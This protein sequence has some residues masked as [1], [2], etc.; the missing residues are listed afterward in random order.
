MIYGDRVGAWST[1]RRPVFLEDP[2]RHGQEG[3][4]GVDFDSRGE[5]ASVRRSCRSRRS[6]EADA[7]MSKG[8]PKPET[9]AHITNDERTDV[10]LHLSK[11]QV[12]SH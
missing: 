4:L 7:K 1:A 11:E 10:S 5:F 3:E 6:I 9:P 12:P 8:E 2:A